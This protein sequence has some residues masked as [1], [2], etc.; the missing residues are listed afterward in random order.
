MPVYFDTSAL[1]KRYVAEPDSDAVDAFV[2]GL[3]GERV[4]S[5]L[6]AT[7]FES[8]LARLQRQQLIDERYGELARREFAADLTATLWQMHAFEPTSFARASL[9]LRELASPLATLNALHLACALELGCDALA[10]GDRQ[11]ARAAAESG[12]AV[13]AFF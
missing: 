13:H 6:V 1:A 8:V 12:L 3:D 9:L 5:P 7:E 10:T 4:I 2:Q 11:L